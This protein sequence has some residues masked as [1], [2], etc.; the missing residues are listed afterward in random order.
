MR[1][2]P[3]GT[4]DDSAWRQADS[5]CGALFYQ[6]HVILAIN[7]VLTGWRGFRYEFVFRALTAR[8]PDPRLPCRHRRYRSAAGVFRSN[9]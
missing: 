5:E 9:A 7:R 2:H 3:R 6:H 4:T 8:P 1:C